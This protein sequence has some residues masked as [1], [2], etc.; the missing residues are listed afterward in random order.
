MTSG[1]R[2]ARRYAR[3]H[4]GT[5]RR[6]AAIL[7]RAW[8]TPHHSARVSRRHP[9]AAHDSPRFSQAEEAP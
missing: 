1:T 2:Y 8:V 6:I 4:T 7:A 5:R 3:A 9:G